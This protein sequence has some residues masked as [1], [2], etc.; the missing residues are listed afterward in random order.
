MCT[1]FCYKWYIVGYISN[2][3]W[4]SC[5][6]GILQC[7]SLKLPLSKH[8]EHCNVAL[9]CCTKYVCMGSIQSKPFS[10]AWQYVLEKNLVLEILSF[11]GGILSIK[12][13]WHFD[14]QRLLYFS[15]RQSIPP[16]C[17]PVSPDFINRITDRWNLFGSNL[18]VPCASCDI[19]YK[20]FSILYGRSY[21]YVAF[22]F[23]TI[24]STHTA[25]CVY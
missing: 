5:E 2:A 13:G 7:I 19:F 12:F 21:V 17:W 6:I 8:F 15:E 23:Q 3:L 9:K 1:Y 25:C 24:D 16:G 20:T 18:C 14:H 4:E 10:N 22:F 11:H